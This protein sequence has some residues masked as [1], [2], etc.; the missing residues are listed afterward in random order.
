MKE[1]CELESDDIC[2]CDH[3]RD[4]HDYSD[5][6]MLPERPCKKCDCDTWNINYYSEFI[7]P[8]KRFYW[9]IF[10]GYKKPMITCVWE[11]RS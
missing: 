11:E 3:R 6:S 2:M 10:K 1:T 8:L 5:T 4:E 7:L 9:K